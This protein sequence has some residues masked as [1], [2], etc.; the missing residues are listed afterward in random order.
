[1]ALWGAHGAG[2]GHFLEKW[3]R[4]SPCEH[5]GLRTPSKGKLAPFLSR[6]RKILPF[7]ISGHLSDIATKWITFAYAPS[8]RREPAA[9]S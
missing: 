7:A 6:Y 4:A 2:V 1:M 5:Q 3:G 9:E 8:V